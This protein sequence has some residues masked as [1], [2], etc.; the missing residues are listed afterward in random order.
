[1]SDLYYSALS[2]ISRSTWNPEFVEPFLNDRG[3][4]REREHSSSSYIPPPMGRE[5][6]IYITSPTEKITRRMSADEYLK[7]ITPKDDEVDLTFCEKLCLPIHAFCFKK[8]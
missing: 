3:V 4:E 1:M 7:Y 2:G 5:P 6:P 8:K